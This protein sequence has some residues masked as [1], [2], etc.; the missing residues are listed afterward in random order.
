MLKTQ[1]LADVEVVAEGLEFP[2]G[3]VA[4]PDG[5]VLVV[6]IIGGRLT[7][8]DADGSK[9]VVAELGGGPNGAAIGPDGAVYVCN[10]GGMP[11]AERG[12]P[13]IQRVDLTTG[14]FTQLYTE[15]EGA[16]L[17]APNDLV[18]DATGN[19]WFT[20]LHGGAIHYATPDGASITPV[21]RYIAE[22]NGVGL[23]PAG[24]V[25]YWAQTR[26]RQVFRRRITAP[27]ELEPSIGHN[28][29]SYVRHGGIDRFTLLAGLPGATEL[30][31]L[32]VDGSGAVCVGGLVDAGIIEV[33]V[34]RDGTDLERV[35]R[36]VLPD[37]LDEHLVTNICFGGEDLTTA[38]LTC[39]MTGRLVRSTWHRPGLR[40]NY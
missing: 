40:L 39:S 5:S 8:I 7:R 2:E 25:L 33:P 11:G 38:Y 14:E 6:E 37:E 21:V 27:G 28:T 1:E 19:F 22:P 13:G 15:C 12:Q 26:T 29:R 30:D 20:D 10:N 17:M 32:A 24:D 16:P 31:S 18:F 34:D 9:E 23:S 3:P 36:W 4:C 35:V